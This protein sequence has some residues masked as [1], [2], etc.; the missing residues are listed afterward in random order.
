MTS[1]THRGFAIVRKPSAMVPNPVNS[2]GQV[3]HVKSQA[4]GEWSGTRKTGW[5]RKLL[6]TK[7]LKIDRDSNLWYITVREMMI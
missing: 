3:P 5:M 1:G 2:I 6:L 7:V 4:D